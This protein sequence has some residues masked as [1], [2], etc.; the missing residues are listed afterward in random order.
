LKDGEKVWRGMKLEKR[1]E[2]E[3]VVEGWI[4]KEEKREM[5][6]GRMKYE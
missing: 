3:G 2:N 1:K 6:C 4:E 5:G